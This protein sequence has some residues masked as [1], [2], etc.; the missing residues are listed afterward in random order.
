MRHHRSLGSCP[1]A[2]MDS[3]QAQA[4]RNG[5][6]FGP[7]FMCLTFSA[8]SR[9]TELLHFQA[10]FLAN[11]NS[12]SAQ[13]EWYHRMARGQTRACSFSTFHSAYFD[14][15]KGRV[16]GGS[17]RTRYSRARVNKVQHGQPSLCPSGPCGA[18]CTGQAEEE[19]KARGSIGP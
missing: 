4:I 2:Q 18:M 11:N 9:R 10:M 3:S 16:K 13:T 1:S 19:R 12:V 5:R 8:I 7:P 15:P 14:I 17:H 6:F